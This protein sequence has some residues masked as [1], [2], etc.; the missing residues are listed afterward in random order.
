M[1]YKFDLFIIGK[2][3]WS[4]QTCTNGDVLKYPTKVKENWKVIICILT[5]D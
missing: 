1:F 5:Q 2:V 3:F 4:E